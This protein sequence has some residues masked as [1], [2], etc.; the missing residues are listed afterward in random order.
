MIQD[1]GGRGQGG[2]LTA[3][4][5]HA[6]RR[7]NFTHSYEGRVMTGVIEYPARTW[8]KKISDQ[9]DVTVTI[10]KGENGDPALVHVWCEPFD[11]Q[12]ATTLFAICTSFSK[13]VRDGGSASVRS[14]LR[15]MEEDISTIAKAVILTEIMRW[16]VELLEEVE[17]G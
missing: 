15:K 10:S 8:S 5:K 11:Q 17:A 16:V 6:I 13:L 14:A 7:I 1:V 12:V 2:R 4:E 9:V 3:R